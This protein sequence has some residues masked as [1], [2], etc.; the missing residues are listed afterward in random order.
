VPEAVLA[1]FWLGLFGSGL[2]Y[3]SY[4]RILQRWGATRTSLVAYLLPVW[5]IA[6]GAIVL[7]EPIAPTMILGTVLII[8]G[9][10]LV[11]SRYGARPVFS[12]RDATPPG[13]TTPT[14]PAAEPRTS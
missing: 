14:T 2:A 6:L 7:S 11:N 1:V 5:G 3:L 4:F 12:R 8:G 9:I 10:A 13:S